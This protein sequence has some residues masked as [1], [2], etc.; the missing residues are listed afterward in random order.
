M[1]RVFKE[2]LARG[3]VIARRSEKLL[4]VR[5]SAGED[6]HMLSTMHKNEMVVVEP[7]LLTQKVVRKPAVAATYSK[8]KARS[9][10]HYELRGFYPMKRER[11]R[12][13]KKVFLQLLMMGTVNACKYY[14]I[15]NGRV[16]D[17]SWI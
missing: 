2:Q 12:W 14:N 3:G 7:K 8:Y 13:W 9:C 6:F 4:A 1:P 10:F 15:K 5:W 11:T 16:M 17:V